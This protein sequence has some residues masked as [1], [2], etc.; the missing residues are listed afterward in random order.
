MKKNSFSYLK[1]YAYLLLAIVALSGCNSQRNSEEVSP[2]DYGC[3]PIQII[4]DAGDTIKIALT[5]YLIQT[6]STD[7][8]YYRFNYASN[9]ELTSISRYST[10]QLPEKLVS[11][12]HL[13]YNSLGYLT[14]WRNYSIEY[15]N[16]NEIKITSPADVVRLQFDSSK[17][18]TAVISQNDTTYGFTYADS[19]SAISPLYI[20]GRSF[21]YII[22][23][24][25]LGNIRGANKDMN[26]FLSDLMPAR[27]TVGNNLE[28]I[29]FNKPKVN[30][31][32]YVTQYQAKT[33]AVALT[34]PSREAVYICPE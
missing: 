33:D 23:K 34:Y 9:G 29:T 14:A 4:K 27:L 17:R 28:R 24:E 26:W 8:G 18:I 31:K 12:D 11:T 32:Y 13:T 2:I 16:D 1:I 5:N 22:I 20:I 21:R 25:L 15:P 7:T 10:N 3:Q 6:I 30:D 19:I